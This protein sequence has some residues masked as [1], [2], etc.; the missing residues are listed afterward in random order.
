MTVVGAD[1]RTCHC[2]GHRVNYGPEGIRTF[3]AGTLKSCEL[4]ELSVWVAAF[5]RKKKTGLFSSSWQQPGYGIR[6][7]TDVVGT[8]T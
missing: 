3:A 6:F 2:F 1:G 8:T 7:Y 4:T 5:L